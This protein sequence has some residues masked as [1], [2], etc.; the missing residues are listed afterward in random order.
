MYSRP[1][2]SVFGGDEI[3][4]SMY[5]S[6]YF[7]NDLNPNDL[8]QRATYFSNQLDEFDGARGEVIFSDRTFEV[9]S[10]QIR[11]DTYVF[12]NSGVVT[13]T[14]ITN[15]QPGIYGTIP[16]EFWEANIA[17]FSGSPFFCK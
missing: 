13:D 6:N 11:N 15:L 7:L 16:V 1:L 2:G 12:D 4:L 3:R 14:R 10:E 8:S 5:R 17:A 9:S